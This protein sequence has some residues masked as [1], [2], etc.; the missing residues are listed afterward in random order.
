[1]LQNTKFSEKWVTFFTNKRKLEK[2]GACGLQ[3][4][5]LKSFL[6]SFWPPGRKVMCHFWPQS[7]FPPNLIPDTYAILV[8]LQLFLII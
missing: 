1:M 8:R 5:S 7:L 3:S 2:I 6:P 4:V